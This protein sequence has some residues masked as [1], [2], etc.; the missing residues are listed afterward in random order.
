MNK[1]VI[2]GVAIAALG[3]IAAVA[4]AARYGFANNNNGPEYAQ[5]TNVEPVKQTT[6]TPHEVCGDETVVHREEYKDRHQIGGLLERSCKLC[7]LAIQQLML[8]QENV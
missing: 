7:D 1:P 3:I 2:A 6:S 8:L 5:V 4:I